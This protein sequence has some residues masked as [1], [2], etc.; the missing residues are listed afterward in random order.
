MQP[1]PVM[2]PDTT[3]VSWGQKVGIHRVP[4]KPDKD[5]DFPLKA[6]REF[7]SPPLKLPSRGKWRSGVPASWGT[8]GSMVCS[9]DLSVEENQVDA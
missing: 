9:E 6:T 2:R 8:G 1:V 7:R 4:L 5:G 3:G